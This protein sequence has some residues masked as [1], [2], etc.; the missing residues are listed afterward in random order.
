MD[1]TIGAIDRSIDRTVKE[2]VD[3]ATTKYDSETH[4]S[5]TKKR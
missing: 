1:G 3:P 5:L 2:V 4:R